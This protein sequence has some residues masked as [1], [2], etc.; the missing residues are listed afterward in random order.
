MKHNN[1]KVLKIRRAAATGIKP[2]TGV[3]KAGL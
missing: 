2:E 1:L 3:Y